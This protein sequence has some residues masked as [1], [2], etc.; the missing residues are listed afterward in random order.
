[1][2]ALPG[3]T[4][5]FQRDLLSVATG[6]KGDIQVT[7]RRNQVSKHRN[8]VPSKGLRHLHG[9]ETLTEGAQNSRSLWS[10]W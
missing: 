7:Q 3:C 2:S 8:A 4:I 10:G 6:A 9:P 5:W 1:M